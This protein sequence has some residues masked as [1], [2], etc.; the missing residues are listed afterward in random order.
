MTYAFQLARVIDGDSFVVTLDL[1]HPDL[2]FD[3]ALRN[4]HIR[5]FGINTPERGQP[6]Y[7][8]ARDF[9]RSWFAT[10]MPSLLTLSCYGLDKY[11]RTLGDVHW[12]ETTLSALLLQNGLAV[13]LTYR[14]SLAQ[15]VQS[16]TPVWNAVRSRRG[17]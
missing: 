4:I 1:S 16:G 2:G 11:G 10:V 5:L 7:T 14:I 8:E 6:G 3:F 12:H 17:R 13:P 15:S 9:V